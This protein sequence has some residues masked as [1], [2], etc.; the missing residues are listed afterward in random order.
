MSR[1]STI[2]QLCRSMS[3][4]KARDS[5]GS[6]VSYQWCVVGAG[7]AGI[8]AVGL[9][10]D[11]SVPSSALLWIDPSFAVGDFGTR[12][13]FVSSNTTVGLFLRFYGHCR[14][15]DFP[16]EGNS[17]KWAIQDLPEKQTC[18][19]DIAAEPL[20]H[21]THNLRQKVH[22]A[23]G[24]VSQLK[25][26][27]GRWECVLSSSAGSISSYLADNVILATGAVPR[28]LPFHH[29]YPS[30]E[31]IPVTTALNPSALVASVASD[32]TVAIFG[33]SHTAIILI[34]TLLEQ[35]SAKKVVNFYREP[36]RYALY[37]NDWILFDD[38]GLK[39]DTARWS[40]E[41]LHGSLPDRLV[42]VF[43]D[44]KTVGE[45][46]PQCTK[47]IYATGFERRQL[48][49]G[50]L[51]LPPRYQYNT[52][53]GIIAPG[54]FGCG[55]GYPEEKTDRY[56]N[57]ELRVG[58]WK[59]MEYLQSVIPLWKEYSVCQGIGQPR[60]TPALSKSANGI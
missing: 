28:T 9:L 22:T 51:G 58:L 13:K 38:T 44:E 17:R 19:L 12:W 5:A 25:E 20:R 55:I 53:C 52:H 8:A 3:A 30:I 18:L 42:R 33:S 60:E 1:S 14:S 16:S 48:P 15:F 24:E 34:R 4:L 6:P 43:S 10:L 47:V 27:E 23:T 57:V 31:E 36:L 50:V 56:G 37:M 45:Y 39:G 35:S 32:D 29:A 2:R 49:N 11:S 59:F 21:I 26:K 41:N 7:P 46:L 40:R 54:L